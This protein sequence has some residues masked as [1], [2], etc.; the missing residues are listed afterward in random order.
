MSKAASNPQSDLF[1]ERF[2]VVDE[3]S[4]LDFWNAFLLKLHESLGT[5]LT[6]RPSNKPPCSLSLGELLA[7]R[8]SISEST[9]RRT[10]ER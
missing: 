4:L 9:S 8:N 6:I 10:A 2:A 3:R 7:S 1:N 5:V